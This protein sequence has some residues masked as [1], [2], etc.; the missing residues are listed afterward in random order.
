MDPRWRPKFDKPR[1]KYPN[2]KKYPNG[3]PAKFDPD[4][5]VQPYPGN[6]IIAHLSPSM[7]SLRFHAS[8]LRQA[9][10]QSPLPSVYLAPAI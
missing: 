7:R 1:P 3:V 9:P 6:T 8:A 5:N 4:G 2:A 10:R